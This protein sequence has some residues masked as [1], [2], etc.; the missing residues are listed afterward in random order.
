MPTII[1]PFL[2]GQGVTPLPRRKSRYDAAVVN[3]VTGYGAVGDGVTDNTAAIQQ[4]IDENPDRQIFFPKSNGIGVYV[5]AGTIYLTDATGRNFQGNLISDNATIKFTT[6][7][8]PSATNAAMQKGIVA[9]AKVNNIGG[10]TSGYSADSGMAIVKGLIFDGPSNGASIYFA[11]S[12]GYQIQNCVFKNARYGIVNECTIGVLI[13]RCRFNNHRNAGIG[14]LMN[15][16]PD[17]WY[18][19]GYWNDG[20]TI[21]KCG[22]SWGNVNGALAFIEDHGT[23][24]ESNRVIIGCTAQGGNGGI[25]TKYGYLGRA[26]YPTLISNWWEE[27]PFPVRIISSN[28]AEGGGATLLTGVT[29]YQP[30]GTYRMDTMPDAYSHGCVLIGNQAYKPNTAFFLNCNGPMF[31]VGNL[32]GTVGVVDL[33]CTQ[34]GKFLVDAGNKNITGTW[35]VSNS[36]GGFLDLAKLVAYSAPTTSATVGATGSAASLPAKPEGYMTVDVNGTPRKIPY[37]KA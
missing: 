22:F 2:T 37:Y 20:Y 11:N 30:T 31:V 26:V 28:A 4:A 15:N 17:V 27:V 36:F 13:Y 7:G 18:S 5:V 12:I 29:G 14:W 32:T 25:G 16:N 34:G 3:V 23:K 6:A 1:S 8:N 10:D 35:T 21:D 33:K 9:Y 24:T 19:G